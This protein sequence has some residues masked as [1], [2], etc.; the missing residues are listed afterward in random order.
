ML[1]AMG[2]K[3]SYNLNNLPAAKAA[4]NRLNKNS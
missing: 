3:P 2:L 4:G 1:R